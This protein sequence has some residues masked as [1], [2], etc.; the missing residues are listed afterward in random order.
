MN[1]FNLRSRKLALVA[2]KAVY[3]VAWRTCRLRAAAPQKNSA[4]EDKRG[5]HF[6]VSVA[7]YMSPALRCP[8]RSKLRREHRRSPVYYQAEQCQSN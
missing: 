4:N 1:R 6:L 7:A 8:A 3:S 5:E 2:A